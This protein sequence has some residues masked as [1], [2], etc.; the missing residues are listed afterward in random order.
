[1]PEIYIGTAGWNV[2]QE[3]K[4]EFSNSGT[5]LERYSQ[6]LN[7]VEIN[8]S[9]YRDHKFET[10]EKWQKSVPQNF[11]FSV[12]LSKYFTHTHS[13]QKT[14]PQ[15]KEVISTMAGLSSKWGLL[16]VQLPPSLQFEAKHAEKFFAKLKKF[17]P[18]P[19]ALEPRHRTWAQPRAL[20][21]LEE[22]DISKVLADPEPCRAP[23]KLRPGVEKSL[24]YFRLHGSPIMYRSLY[25]PELLKK[26][27]Y[28]IRHPIS[29]AQQTW[30]I[31]DNSTY[32]RATI[33]ALQL[34]ELMK[35]RSDVTSSISKSL[36]F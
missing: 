23:L 35:G 14:G 12:K 3:I 15:L 27:V 5:H 34:T 1:M 19:V 36:S 13:L 18:V 31:F 8:S 25:E 33:N 26:I 11:R 9:F 32:G 16:L 10:Y 2:P 7:A 21:L 20:K 28:R 22:Y 29:P 4:T 30:V 6:T 17:C 24:R